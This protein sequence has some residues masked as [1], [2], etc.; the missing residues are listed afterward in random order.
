[1][2]LTPILATQLFLQQTLRHIA[3]NQ[4]MA[5]RDPI[6]AS[7]DAA[8]MR[9][10]VARNLAEDNPGSELHGAYAQK[11]EDFWFGIAEEVR[12]QVSDSINTE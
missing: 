8:A 1:M 3:L 2:D 11:V 10:R 9:I 6:E 12:M 7:L 4:L 5:E